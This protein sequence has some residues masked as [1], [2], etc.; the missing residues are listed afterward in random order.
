M[1]TETNPRTTYKREKGERNG[2]TGVI[3][4]INGE[5]AKEK[6]KIRIKRPQ[7]ERDLR[8]KVARKEKDKGGEGG[9]GR[10]FNMF[11]Y[12]CT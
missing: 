5:E 7:K 11:F 12:Q 8:G 10:E 6:K 9:E 4:R 2:R 1:K 3:W